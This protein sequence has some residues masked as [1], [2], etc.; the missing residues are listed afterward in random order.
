L[1]G[2]EVKGERKRRCAELEVKILAR[3]GS[4]SPKSRETTT[5]FVGDHS[6]SLDNIIFQAPERAALYRAGALILEKDLR[7]APY[8]FALGWRSVSALR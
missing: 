2:G 3:A 7:D 8:I 4:V 6:N 5:I 1:I